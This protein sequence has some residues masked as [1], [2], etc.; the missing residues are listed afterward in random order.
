MFLGPT[1][2]EFFKLGSIKF[3]LLSTFISEPPHFQDSLMRE[4]TDL[5]VT[6]QKEDEKQSDQ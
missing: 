1:T 5:V 4:K 2:V 3:N 6:E